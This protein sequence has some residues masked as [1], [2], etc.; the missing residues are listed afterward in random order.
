MLAKQ[1]RSAPYTRSTV[2][3]RGTVAQTE[4]KLDHPSRLAIAYARA[5]LNTGPG[6]MAVDPLSSGVVRRALVV[7]MG[8]LS[9]ADL[10]PKQ[11][12]RAVRSCCS[13]FPPDEDTQEAA[14]KRLQAHNEGASLPPWLDVLRGPQWAQQWKDFEARH[15]VLIEQVLSA[16]RPRRKGSTTTTNE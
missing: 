14:W 8:H 13:S 12:A 11:E 9:R 2:A 7:Y 4:V 10:D 16:R 15:E 1:N 3:L 5:W 6:G